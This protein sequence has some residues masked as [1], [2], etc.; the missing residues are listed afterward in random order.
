M[1]VYDGISYN[2]I[3]HIFHDFLIPKV[4]TLEFGTFSFIFEQEGRGYAK[5]DLDL[6]T[7]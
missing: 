5:S 7:Q 6:E 1:T 2:T 3:I 4:L